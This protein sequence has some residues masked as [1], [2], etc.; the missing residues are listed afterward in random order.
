MVLTVE[1]INKEGCDRLLCIVEGLPEQPF[2][3]RDRIR[4]LEVQL[5]LKVA[6]DS[7]RRRVTDNHD[8]AR[9]TREGRGPAR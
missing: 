5:A 9:T 8:E 4:D 6:S 3:V 1:V 7:D 2:V